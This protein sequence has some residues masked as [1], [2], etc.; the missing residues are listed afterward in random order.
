MEFFWDFLE[1]EKKGSGGGEERENLC[2]FREK[3]K[4]GGKE[5]E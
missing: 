1:R 3:V 5:G 4:V 2:E